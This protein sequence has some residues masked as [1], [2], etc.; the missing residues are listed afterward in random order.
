MI[1]WYFKQRKILFFITWNLCGSNMKGTSRITQRLPEKKKHAEKIDGDEIKR[2]PRTS[3]TYTNKMTLKF[4]VWSGGSLPI[5]NF[6]FP[7]FSSLLFVLIRSCSL[8][9][10][11]HHHH[12]H[13]SFRKLI[14]KRLHFHTCHTSTIETISSDWIKRF[15][16]MK[17]RGVQR[18]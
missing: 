17:I 7:F 5:H 10:Q 3:H 13:Q 18:Q 16:A 12:Q 1:W 11:N 2:H 4:E 8:G 6:L 9:I 14:F 15:K